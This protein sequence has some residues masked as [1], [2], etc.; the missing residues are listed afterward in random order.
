MTPWTPLIV[1]V[2]AE[3]GYEIL[4]PYG[5]QGVLQLHKLDKEVVFGVELGQDHRAL[6]VEREPLLDAPHPSPLRKVQE[7]RQVEDYGRGED[8]VP[9]QKVDLYL[10]WVA[11]PTEDVY[12]VPALLGVAAGRVV[13]DL[14]Q[15]GDLPVELGVELGLQDAPQHGELGDLLALET[16]RVVEDLAVPVTEY[17]GRVPAFQAEQPR[18][19]T[20]GDDRLHQGLAGLEVLARH[21][22]APLVG[23]LGEGRY[24]HGQRR[25]AVGVRHS[26]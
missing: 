21:R 25:S 2:E 8:R 17:V 20:R 10:H 5:S 1:V 12:V 18:L 7:Q 13:V 23:E 26:L 24:V 14:D 16:A 3:V 19:Q 15:V 11:E 4:A 22:H 6:E 9:T